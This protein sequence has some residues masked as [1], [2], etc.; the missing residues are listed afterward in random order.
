MRKLLAHFVVAALL[1]SCQT[2]DD[3]LTTS[4]TPVAV[5]GPAA[6]A[7]AG[8]MAS[9]LAEQIG[10]ASATTTIKLE[11]DTS[12]FA[13]ALE[14]ALKGWGYTVV[15]DGK[16]AKDVKPVELAYAIDGFDGQVLA[17][18]STPSIALGRAYTPTAAGAA[19]ASPLS[20]IQR[21]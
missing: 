21:N 4:S 5:T 11:K 18:L 3:A 6:S 1:S 20:I 10:P 2:A 14:A 16:V 17:R 19:P 7:I 9:R 12:E 13:A 15:T 8:D